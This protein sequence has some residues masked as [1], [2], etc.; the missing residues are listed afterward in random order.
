MTQPAT[1]NG[2][3]HRALPSKVGKFA[4]ADGPAHRPDKI[5]LYGVGS[6]G[7]ST[8]AASAPRPIFL[9]AE[10]GLASISAPKIEFEA[11]SATRSARVTPRT[12]EEIYD[13]IAALEAEETGFE[14][15]VLDGLTVV[16]N[17]CQDLV[18]RQNA[19]WKT[20]QTPGFGQG[21]AATLEVWRVLI[22]KLD[23]LSIKRR[24]RLILIGH[25]IV[26]K[27]RNPEG[28]EFERYQLDVTTHPKGNVAGFLFGWADIFGFARFETLTVAEGKRS[29]AFGEGARILHLARANAYDAKCRPKG[30]REKIPMSWD[31]LADDIANG[32]RSPE[33]LRDEF[34][35]LLEQVDP[36]TRKAAEAW[37]PTAG[38]DAHALSQAIDRLRGKAMLQNKEEGGS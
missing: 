21:E 30:V 1:T 36:E 33:R 22:S 17:L 25:S 18:V 34:S 27:F 3:G 28:P 12:I 11:A 26:T 35:R 38:D 6:V 4:I 14:T 19:K 20:I 15:F 10:D 5:V 32:W 31:E 13:V 2:I 9:C 16:D 8:L 7:K 24:M 29:I 37:L 23:S